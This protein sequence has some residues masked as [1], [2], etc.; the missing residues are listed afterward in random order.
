[1]IDEGFKIHEEM[2]INKSIE[3]IADFKTERS[4]IVCFY[5]C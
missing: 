5:I 4:K 3:G 2:K 1:M